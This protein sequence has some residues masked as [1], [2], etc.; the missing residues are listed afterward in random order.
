MNQDKIIAA[1]QLAYVNINQ[2]LYPEI[3]NDDSLNNEQKYMMIKEKLNLDFISQGVQ[4][5]QKNLDH[6]KT[7]KPT[8]NS[9]KEIHNE[10]IALFDDLVNLLKD[11]DALNNQIQNNDFSDEIGGDSL[12]KTLHDLYDRNKKSFEKFTLWNDSIR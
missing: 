3:L 7:I 10:L 8:S 11:I 1:L 5:M 4:V 6:I 12:I 9:V 2:S